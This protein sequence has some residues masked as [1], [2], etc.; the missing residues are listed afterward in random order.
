MDIYAKTEWTQTYFCDIYKWCG[1]ISNS[2]ANMLLSIGFSNA[3]R[4][5]TKIVIITSASFD[6]VV[7][8][9]LQNKTESHHCLLPCHFARH[10][11]GTWRTLQVKPVFV[12]CSFKL[13]WWWWCWTEKERLR[14]YTTRFIKRDD[15]HHQPTSQHDIIMNI[16]RCCCVYIT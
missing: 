7:L 4:C 12:F 15:D 6:D 3:C 2:P 13:I 10:Q 1:I 14:L 9:S 11:K 8:T 16:Y 5:P